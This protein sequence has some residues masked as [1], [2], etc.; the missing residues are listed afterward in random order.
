MRF[1]YAP[2]VPI[3]HPVVIFQFSPHEILEK[4]QARL[5]D[6]DEVLSILSS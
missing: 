3:M 4:L 2:A 6:V 5:V 1:S